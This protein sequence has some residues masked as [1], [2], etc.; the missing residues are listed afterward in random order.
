MRASLASVAATLLALASASRHNDPSSTQMQ[1][2][3]A[4]MDGKLPAATPLGFQWNGVPRR[5]YVSAEQV[6]WDYA[7]T[8]VSRIDVCCYGVHVLTAH[9]VG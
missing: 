9:I 3:A 1:A 8:G 7:P 6:E 5:Y 2:C 4:S